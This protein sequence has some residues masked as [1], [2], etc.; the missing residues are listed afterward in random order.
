MSLPTRCV[1]SL[2]KEHEKYLGP[3]YFHLL[4]GPHHMSCLIKNSRSTNAKHGTFWACRLAIFAIFEFPHL[5]HTCNTS[6]PQMN[7]LDLVTL[8][9]WPTWG[10]RA[11]CGSLAGFMW[12]L[13]SQ[14]VVVIYSPLGAAWCRCDFAFFCCW[15]HHKP[16][17]LYSHQQ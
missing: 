15:N 5:S 10:S 6:V 13:G 16:Y 4:Q 7:S 9:P 8:Q 17:F 12:L 1:L 14:W 11:S 2:L 3:L